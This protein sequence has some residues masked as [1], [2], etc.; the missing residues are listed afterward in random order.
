MPL[1]KEQWEQMQKLFDHIPTVDVKVDIRGDFLIDGRVVCQG[2]A[3][4]LGS[5]ALKIE[6]EMVRAI[7]K[8][9]ERQ[10]DRI[11]AE[12]GKIGIR[13]PKP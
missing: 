3:K 2:F 8:A 12:L 1:S 11:E 9:E 4:K 7:T 10:R 5:E 6:V 13:L